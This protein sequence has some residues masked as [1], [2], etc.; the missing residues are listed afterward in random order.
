MALGAEME[1]PESDREV[2]ALSEPPVTLARPGVGRRPATS[3]AEIEHLALELFARQGFEAT[4]V[5]DIAGAAGIGRRTFFRYYASKNDVPWGDFDATLERMRA[6]LADL[7][8][9]LPPMQAL[10]TAVLDFNRLD[11]AEEPWHRRRMALILRVPALQAHSMLKYRAW[12]EVVAEFAA[13]RYGRPVTDLLP[14][15]VGWAALG[16]A[17]AAY[18]RWLDA[19]DADLAELLDTGFRD[20]AAGFPPP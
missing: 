17:I 9:D 1:E 11:P 5:D 12:R 7:P 15:T 10:R 14:R 2:R 13:H 3:R 4:T 18:E 16:T 8:A 20:L 19:D 6:L